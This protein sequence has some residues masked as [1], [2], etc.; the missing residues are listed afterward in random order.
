M[1]SFSI[2][3]YILCFLSFLPDVMGENNSN[4]EVGGKVV[5]E[6]GVPLSG[7]EIRRHFNGTG[8]DRTND[9]GM[10]LFTIALNEFNDPESCCVV[11]FSLSGYKQV[12][13][14]FKYG[15]RNIMV[16][17][18][19]GES[20]WSPP[21]CDSRSKISNRIGWDLKVLLP[22]EA[23]IKTFPDFDNIRIHIGFKS[24]PEKEHQWMELGTGLLWLPGVP[25]YNLLLNHKIEERTIK[26]KDHYYEY[27]DNMG[28]IRDVRE[29]IGM[30]YRGI[31]EN[32]KKW[33][34]VGLR[35][36]TI[37]YKNA[38]SEAAEYF[39]KIIDSLCVDPFRVINGEQRRLSGI[40]DLW[41]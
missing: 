26:G 4:N 25:Y 5:N 20:V 38:T 30:D 16:T 22:Q 41:N 8:S 33:R 27:S 24:K 39:D 7:V 31:D 23:E 36:Q 28:N 14:A 32:G 12:T 21:L 6:Q 1:K 29:H 35:T 13:K 19:H 40:P 9:N 17:M 34:E 3:F 10:F 15:T 2:L 37:T 18:V 11:V